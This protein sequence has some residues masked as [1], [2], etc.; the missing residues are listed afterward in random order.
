VAMAKARDDGESDND[1]R[2]GLKCR[3]ERD[4]RRSLQDF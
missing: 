2:D 4:S 1:T 3:K